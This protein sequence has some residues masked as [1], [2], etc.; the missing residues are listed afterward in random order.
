MMLNTI[1]SSKMLLAMARVE[2]FEVKQ[3]L[4]GFKWL[5]NWSSRYQQS[6]YCV[7]FA[8]EEA[9]G[10]ALGEQIRDKDGVTAAAGV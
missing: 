2:G 10:F 6:G 8:F 4:T 3:T 9:I 1:V 7:P 5:G